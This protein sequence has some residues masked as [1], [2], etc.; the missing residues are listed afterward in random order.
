M[1][2]GFSLL[3]HIVPEVAAA[4]EL[5]PPSGAASWI[6]LAISC[7]STG[8]LEESFFRFYLLR[9][10]ENTLPLWASFFMGVTLFSFCHFYEGLW[11]ILNAV[12][13]GIF[14]S[15]LFIRFKSLH[16]IAWAHGAYN[17]FVYIMALFNG[18]FY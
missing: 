7:F 8:Y 17:T 2:F 18:T 15:F 10:L 16:G 11:G 13:A 12:S 4:A 1:G 9:K 6:V 3:S 5:T 14:L